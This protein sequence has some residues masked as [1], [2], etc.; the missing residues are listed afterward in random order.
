MDYSLIEKYLSGNALETE[1]QEIFTWIESSPENKATFIHYK[2]IWSLSASNTSDHKLAL[3]VIQRK[4]S[5]NKRRK[6]LVLKYA[7]VFTGLFI[8]S[9]ILYYQIENQ[10]NYKIED[11][12]KTIQPVLNQVTLKLE[13]GSVKII[14]NDKDF[15]IL[16]KN[17]DLVGQKEDSKLVYNNTPKKEQIKQ[18]SYNV[19]KVPYGK[20]FEIEL[21]DGSL[22]HLN[23]GSSLKYPVQFIKGQPRKIYFE[24]EA[25]FE[26]AK[27]KEHPF[28]INVEDINISVLGTQFN[29][30]FYPEDPEINTVLVEG[31][32]L[33]YEEGKENDK[34]SS[35]LLT[36]NHKASWNKSKKEMKVDK[37]DISTFVAWKDGILLFKNMPF[38]NIIKKLERH[39]DLT[40][41]NQYE[42]LNNQKYT[43]SFDLE[44]IEDILE[45]F[46]EDTPFEYTKSNNKIIIT[47]P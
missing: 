33:L 37:V 47:N 26:I 19:L 17:G 9:S 18:L 4:I 25:Y 40:I 13:D 8:I 45:S 2:K 29:L 22:V 16:D 7:A 44:N 42:F 34:E 21:S 11:Q 31:S 41:E 36:P 3:Q 39:F 14:Q 6:L 10:V 5:K 30:S 24:G 27:D 12:V 32:V 43:A 28:L 38:I 1:V 20:R 35:V 23:A 15:N 46:K